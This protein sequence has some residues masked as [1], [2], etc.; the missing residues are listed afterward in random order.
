MFNYSLATQAL[1]PAVVSLK[2]YQRKIEMEF[3]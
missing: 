2:V 3:Q 1:I